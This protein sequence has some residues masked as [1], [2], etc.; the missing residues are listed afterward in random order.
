MHVA[1]GAGVRLH[2]L[3]SKD[4]SFNRGDRMRSVARVGRSIVAGVLVGACHASTGATPALPCAGHAC[5]LSVQNHDV[6]FLAL[7]YIDSSGKTTLLGLV[8]PAAVRIF[9][10]QWVKSASV[11]VVVNVQKGGTY[12]ADIVLRS[13]QPNELHF[14]D[15][16]EPVVDGQSVSPPRVNYP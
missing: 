10:V 9:H 4:G 14:P 5:A 2:K 11:R 6:T 1:L 16:F 3:H 12:F 13:T 15:D 8:N 7:R